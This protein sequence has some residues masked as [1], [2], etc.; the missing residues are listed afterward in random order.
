MKKI[1]ID[2]N[3]PMV[4]SQ[5]G[6]RRGEFAYPFRAMKVSDSFAIP[7]KKDYSKK[8]INVL[9]SSLLTT[10]RLFC[11]FNRFDWKFSTRVTE[12]EIRI[13]RIK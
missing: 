9:R 2:K 1:K 3:I 4:D 8:K 6:R 5:S 13:W 10:G 7:V 11:Q 12:K